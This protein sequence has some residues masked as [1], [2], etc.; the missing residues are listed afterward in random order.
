MGWQRGCPARKANTR[1]SDPA[2]AT[3]RQPTSCHPERPSAARESKDLSHV[4]PHP[5][6]WWGPTA[7]CSAGRLRPAPRRVLS[8]QGLPGIQPAGH[9]SP[10]PSRPA[11]RGHRAAPAM[12][13]RES[14]PTSAGGGLGGGCPWADSA[15]ARGMSFLPPALSL[16]KGGRKPAL[17]PPNGWPKA[18]EGIMG[19]QRGCPAR[20]AN[21]R[22]SDPAPRPGDRAC[23]LWLLSRHGALRSHT[24]VCHAGLPRETARACSGCL[25]GSSLAPRSGPWAGRAVARGMSFL[26]WEKWPKA[27]EGIMG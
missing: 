10:T 8:R 1:G 20:K 12:R 24:G 17:S 9:P 4:H 2:S 22:G 23:L 14:P 3:P 25:R 27:D 7:P 26:P 21:T 6:P 16:S 13:A 5:R 18:N 15:V 19:W 11:G